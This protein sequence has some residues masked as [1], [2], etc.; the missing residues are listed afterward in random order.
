MLNKDASIA[1][2]PMAPGRD[3]K[4]A[5]LGLEPSSGPSVECA[6][7][8]VPSLFADFRIVQLWSTG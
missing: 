2:V 1:F 8:G 5:S 4:R 6:G 7:S 3:P